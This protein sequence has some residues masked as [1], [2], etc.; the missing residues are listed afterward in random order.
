MSK[1]ERAAT[2]LASPLSRYLWS[3]AKARAGLLRIVTYH[4]VLDDDPR[5]FPFDEE[6]ISACSRTFRAQM[7]FARRHFNVISFADLRRY[8]AEGRPWPERALI[9]T[10]DDGYRDSYTCAFPIL[11]ELGLQATF[12][13]P[14][15]HIGQA[16]LFW[17]DFIA[18]CCKRARRRAV[19]L[20]D[21]SPEPIPLAT[22]DE[23]RAATQ[24]I[25][26]WIKRAPEETK[27]RFLTRLSHELNVALPDGLAEGMHLTWAE[28]REMAAYGIEFGSHT[29]THPVLSNVGAAQLQEEIHQSKKTLEENIGKE[30]IAFAY[31]VGGRATFDGATQRAVMECGFSYAVSYMGGA[32]NETSFDRYALPR[33]SVEACQPL[34][35]F[36]S[37]LMFPKL[38]LR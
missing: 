25:L 13:L 23:K 38:M 4:R 29:V 8:E 35:V 5:F 19:T 1:R 11:Q 16:R 17:W 20:Y 18:Y 21:I 26:R 9:I 15:G 31:P 3:Y 32:I 27:N 14:T 6:V 36:Q 12:F 37:N 22:A 33:I 24:T 2:I 30:V 28:V 7:E 10:F 34:T